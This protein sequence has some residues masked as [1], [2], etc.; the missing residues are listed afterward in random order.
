MNDSQ[1]FE[2]TIREM[3]H[4]VRTPLTSIMGFAELLLEDETI[5]GQPREYLEVISGEARRL[6]EMLN[7]YLSVLLVESDAP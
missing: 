4:D 5:I 3:S 7:H 6:S 2:S 1:R